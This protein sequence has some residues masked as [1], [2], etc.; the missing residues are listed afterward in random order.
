VLRRTTRGFVL[1]DLQ[2]KNGSFVNGDR[3]GETVLDDGDLIELGGTFLVFRN[4]GDTE[5]GPSRS[6]LGVETLLPQ[7]ASEL[8]VAVDISRSDVPL[9]LL[10]ETGTG[11]EVVARAAH[12]ESGRPGAMIAVNC[13]ALPVSL[14]ES[15]LFG[16]K[17][18]AFSGADADRSGLIAAAHKGTL[19]LDE[20]GEL[21]M[22]AQAA[23][24]RV[25]QDG[26]VTPLGATKPIACDV[27]LIS[28]TNRDLSALVDSGRFRADLYARVSGFRLR[29]WPLRDR[30]EDLGLLI[31]S[32]LRRLAGDRASTIS[33]SVAAVRRLFQ[34]PWP[35][36]IRELEK[37]LSAAVVLRIDQIKSA[38]LQLASVTTESPTPSPS[39]LKASPEHDAR[40]QQL[41]ELL[42]R[43]DGNISAV[44]RE[45]GK[46]RVQIRRWIRMYRLDRKR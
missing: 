29:L 6:L 22:P 28:A 37:T 18:G 43:H 45:M 12:A 10:G 3:V 19:F 16:S 13:A 31:A 46:A 20:I 8:S 44:A 9:V 35:F 33:F 26:E 23:L 41:R 21:P 32:L 39:M 17:K 11:K 30:K 15:E 40:R 2:S 38:H 36:N 14:V 25:L 4:V 7:L 5:T 27:R 34:Y 24:L 42:L 1:Q